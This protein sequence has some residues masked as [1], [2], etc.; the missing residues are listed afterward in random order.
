LAFTGNFQATSGLSI[1]LGTREVRRGTSKIELTRT[2]YV[3][4]ELL[5]RNAG[6]V[7]TRES[8]IES[9]WGGDSE[10]ESNTLDAFTRLLRG[11]HRAQAARLQTWNDVLQR[12]DSPSSASGSSRPTLPEPALAIEKGVT[13]RA[14]TT[15]ESANTR[16]RI[17]YPA[18]SA[19]PGSQRRQVHGGRQRDRLRLDRRRRR[20]A[21][22]GGFRGRH[23]APRR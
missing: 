5:M 8:L 9:V 17:R 12:L 13:S 19:N 14:V 2:E 15:E 21:D 6:R 1:H 16:R 22:R 23:S 10:I 3:L 4:L 18:H 7:L 20:H 11:I